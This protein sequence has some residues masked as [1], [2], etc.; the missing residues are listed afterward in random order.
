[1]L[2]HLTEYLYSTSSSHETSSSRATLNS[3]DSVVYQT[4]AAAEKSPDYDTPALRVGAF[5]VRVFGQKKV[6]NEDV[7]NI[8]VQVVASFF[9]PL[10]YVF[11][12]VYLT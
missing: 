10:Q 8:L 9:F 5:N 11:S 3:R 1:M 2:E 4:S 12:D 7:L 6:A